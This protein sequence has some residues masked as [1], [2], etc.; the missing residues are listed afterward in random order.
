MVLTSYS[1]GFPPWFMIGIVCPLPKTS[2]VPEVHQIRPITVLAQL[3]RLWSSVAVCQL[4][5][6]LSAWA[7]PG[8]TGLLPGRGAQTV[9]YRT[10]FWL[11]KALILKN[12]FRRNT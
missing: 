1:A 2:T 6:R 10:Q 7:P 9:G 11:E 4:L 12:V 8:V 3:Y 5:R